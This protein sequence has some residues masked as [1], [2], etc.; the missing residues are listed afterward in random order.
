MINPD[1]PVAWAKLAAAEYHLSHTF[2]YIMYIDM[3]VVI[4]NMV[5]DTT[6]P[7]CCFLLVQVSNI[8]S[9]F[10]TYMSRIGK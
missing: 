3:D 2:D 4:M 9:L 7:H 1:R 8:I 5:R 6:L 10:R